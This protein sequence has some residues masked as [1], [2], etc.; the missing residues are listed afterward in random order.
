MTN[1][2]HK[3]KNNLFYNFPVL[4]TIKLKI[5]SVT[6]ILT[7]KIKLT[8]LI[9]VSLQLNWNLEPSPVHQCY[10]P[11]QSHFQNSLRWWRCALTRPEARSN[12]IKLSPWASCQHK[13][14]PP[15]SFSLSKTLQLYKLQ[16]LLFNLRY[17]KKQKNAVP[18]RTEI[19]SAAQCPRLHSR[20]ELQRK[21]Q[22]NAS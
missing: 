1:F 12:V 16:I 14:K 17:L 20:D 9:I 11:R 15:N 7:S 18:T 19:Q 4:K 21:L 6:Y 10:H 13:L 22:I 2:K 8:N 3:I 5:L